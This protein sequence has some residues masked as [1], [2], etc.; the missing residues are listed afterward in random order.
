MRF[1]LLW[2]SV[3]LFLHC[4]VATEVATTHREV[5]LANIRQLTFG[6]ENAE[7]YFSPNG[8]QLS[9]QSTR[10]GYPCDQIYT[11]NADGSE[12]KR[13]SNGAG[14]TT[15]AYFYRD[16]SRILFS[17]TH[18]AAPEC[19][20][21]AD[22]SRGYVWPLYASYDIY[23]SKPDGSDL[24]PLM[25]SPGY[26]AEA[27]ISPDGK[28]IVFTS[29]RDGDIE[30]YSMDLDGSHVMRLT[31]SPGYDGGA[32]YSPDSKKIV[33]RGHHITD[34]TELK[35][36]RDLLKQNLVKPAK[37]EIYV[38]DADGKNMQQVT[39][40][41]AANFCPY[42]HP[43]GKRI[44]FASN[45]NDPKGRNFD[46]FLIN[47]DGT[48]QEQIT[49]NDTFDGFPMFNPDGSKL[50]FASN[51][52][53]AKPGET[54]IFIADWIDTPDEISE[55]RLKRDVAYLASDEMKGRLTGS[56]EARRAAEYIA[57]EFHKSGLKD[58]PGTTGPYQQF[59]FT[60]GVKLGTGNALT[61]DIKEKTFQT[62]STDFIPAGFSDDA[63]LKSVSAVFA[64]FGIRGPDLK[65]DDY[66][67]LDVKGKA[68]LVYRYGPEG[69]DPKSEYA[70]FYPLRYKALI[71]REQGAAAL[72]ILSDEDDEL[73]QLHPDATF[74]TAGIPV[75]SVKRSVASK[76]FQ[77]AGMKMPDP[78]NPHG[79]DMELPGML[80]SLE[81]HLL[82]EK[83]KSDNV[84][85]WLPAT[86]ATDATIVIGAHY[87]HLGMGIE[88]SL[89]PKWGVV[90]NGAD[91]NASGVAGLLELARV[92]SK[93]QLKRN[94]LFIAF[95]G[96]EL[97]VL[98]SSYFVKSPVLPIKNMIAMEN[99]DMIGRLRNQKLVVGGVGTSPAWKELLTAANQEQLDLKFQED[100]YG[101]S[102]HTSFY[103]KDIPVL[104]YFTGQH[105]EYHKPEDDPAT[106]EYPG[107]AEVIRYV[108]RV[109]N[110]IEERTKAPAFTRV[111]GGQQE[112]A[113]RGFRVYLGTIPDYTESVKGVKLSGVRADSPAEKAGLKAGDVIVQ[114]GDRKIENIYDYTFALQE[115][116]AGETVSIIVQRDGKDVTVQATLEKRSGG[117]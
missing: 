67:G 9:F 97:G 34:E 23:S 12:L 48:G 37:L 61:A 68:V 2:I 79:M 87:D 28:K 8:K 78:K 55:E 47:T 19:P 38:M 69:D 70:R 80:L 105:A 11:M 81:C 18:T 21:S 30:L 74:G 17:S 92:F 40:N 90:H 51:R 71:A 16:G 42:F 57:G 25:Q 15:C 101:P 7:A 107:L 110:G 27:T 52:N 104:F 112:T 33:Y 84:I 96:E 86:P 60:S 43:D 75:I 36:F 46:L 113:G 95:S 39:R 102:D 59:E 98:G 88:G 100:G 31:N 109:T 89:A 44:V 56:P 58:A 5:H 116:K 111:K 117:Q 14:R 26:D 115:H 32:F 3:F 72:L 6:G 91:D 76:W 62:D 13:L 54:N 108:A 64:G 35:E 77:E 24:R 20:P 29:D 94:L 99:M 45:L 66:T 41:D 114:F 106:L 50:V 4:A 63:S 22:R 53:D 93:R 73:L 82:R 103:S 1:H 83:S 10:D 49:F 65:W 85:G